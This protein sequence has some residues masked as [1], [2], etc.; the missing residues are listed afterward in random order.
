VL[1]VGGVGE[2]ELSVVVVEPEDFLVLLHLLD[3]SVLEE[4]NVL[5][6]INLVPFYVKEH[7]L[8]PLIVSKEHLFHHPIF[9]ELELTVLLPL[10]VEGEHTEA[11]ILVEFPL[12]QDKPIQHKTLVIDFVLLTKSE[13]SSPQNVLVIPF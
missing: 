7:G 3:L 4:L 12:L 6:V 8:T 9:E 5:I 11:P 2:S 13:R 1:A 10:T